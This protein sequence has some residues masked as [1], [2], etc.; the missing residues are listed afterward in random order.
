VS[1]LQHLAPRQRA[2]L[3]LRDVLGFHADEV[4]DMLGSSEASVNSAL[5]RA[6]GTLE[7]RLP[8][9]QERVAVPNGGEDATM[10]NRFA[11]AF[12]SDDIDGVIALLT[13]DAIVSMPPEPEWHQGRAA[14]DAFLR[15]RHLDRL[16]RRWRFYRVGAN[17]QPAYVYYFEDGDQWVRNGIFVLGVRP[18]GIESITRFHDDGLLD[19]F[20]APER[21]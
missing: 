16:P 6:R 13:E 2:V 10:V 1:G 12:E 21:L 20:G 5:Q 8:P 7:K 18:D 19:R 9:R 11:N 3:V 4:A 15:A 17:L 14:I